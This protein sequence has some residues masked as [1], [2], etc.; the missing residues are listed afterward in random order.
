MIRLPTR[1]RTNAVSRLRL[2][3][4]RPGIGTFVVAMLI[5][6]FGLYITYP[7]VLILINSF[8]VAG[9]GQPAEW[10]LDNW[11]SAF[12]NP[13]I[14][15]ALRNTFFIYFSYTIVAFPSA[16]MIAWVLARTKIKWS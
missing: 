16:V 13:S 4:L 5:L 15:G 3:T 1:P 8:N 12:S 9:I 2:S 14:W 11:R 10:S 7:V 6:F